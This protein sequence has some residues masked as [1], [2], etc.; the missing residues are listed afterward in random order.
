MNIRFFPSDCGLYSLLHFKWF[1]FGEQMFFSFC[2][3][4]GESK[5]TIVS[6]SGLLGHY[7][8]CERIYLPSFLSLTRVIFII[9]SHLP[10][11]LHPWASWVITSWNGRFWWEAR[12]TPIEC[13]KWADLCDH[14]LFEG[15][16]EAFGEAICLKDQSLLWIE[17][18]PDLAKV[19][20]KRAIV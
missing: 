7:G 16:V 8:F 15:L 13:S 3:C 2:Y 5:W 18:H 1:G 10:P 9:I 4:L 14:L 17:G 19:G 6:F 20:D 11:M 12:V